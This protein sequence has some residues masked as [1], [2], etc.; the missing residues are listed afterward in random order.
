MKIRVAGDDS[1]QRGPSEGVWGGCPILD[2]IE[3][4]SVGY[5]F[6]DD[7]LACNNLVSSNV[8][9]PQPG[10]YSYVDTSSSITQLVTEVG[11]VLR[12]LLEAA[13]NEECSMTT[14]LTAGMGKVYSTAPKNLWFET[15]VR[16]GQITDQGCFIGLAEEA[17]PANSLLADTTPVM[18]KDQIGFTVAIA[19]PS[20]LNAAY[21]KAAT[22]TIHKAGAQTLVAATWYKLGLFYDA[23]DDLMMWFV[24]GTQVGASLDVSATTAFPDGEEVCPLFALKTIT[25]AASSLD[26]DWVR[27]AQLC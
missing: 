8:G 20:A 23:G 7:F 14:G 10:W 2:M 16:F 13:A 17:C 12:I 6:F 4:P 24:D 5:H 25:G 9:Y 26:I 27:F 3:D 18:T 15:R 11:G 21:G 1:A 19:T 22:P